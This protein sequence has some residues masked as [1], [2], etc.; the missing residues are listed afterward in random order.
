MLFLSDGFLAQLLF[1]YLVLSSQILD[2]VLLLAINPTCQNDEVESPGLKNKA[3]LCG[4]AN[5]K[6]F[7]ILRDLLSVKVRRRPK[8]RF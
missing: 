3:H 7:T 5:A 4:S 2:H 1:E 6:I 8:C